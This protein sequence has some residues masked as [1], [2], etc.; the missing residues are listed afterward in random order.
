M[1]SSRATHKP[2][3]SP[4]ATTPLHQNPP[5]PTSHS[6][7]PS[8]QSPTY[9]ELP[10]ERMQATKRSTSTLPRKLPE[11]S[12]K[13]QNN[14]TRT[15]S[16]GRMTPQYSGI[17]KAGSATHGNVKSSNGSN[18]PI[19]AT[20]S[21]END[22]RF[23]SP[24]NISAR[25][26]NGTRSPSPHQVHTSGSKYA[27]PVQSSAL[28]VSDS[29]S[30][31]PFT[32]DTAEIASVESRLDKLLMDKNKR[33]IQAMESSKLS[34]V[35][36][37]NSRSQTPLSTISMNISGSVGDIS[38]RSNIPRKKPI[39]PP[40]P[41]RTTETALQSQKQSLH[42]PSTLTRSPSVISDR[43]DI[44]AHSSVSVQRPPSVFSNKS[45]RSSR[46][47]VSSQI[48]RKDNKTTGSRS[49]DSTLR[50]SM[51]SGYSTELQYSHR[52]V[53]ESDSVFRKRTMSRD[54]NISHNG[55]IFPIYMQVA[56]K[57][58]SLV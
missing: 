37:T 25:A 47:H 33:N 6:I 3:L 28:D 4:R 2:Q 24:A 46:S 32:I 16:D 19:K 36:V 8:P 58:C 42:P 14:R 49:R 51:E 22:T 27:R 35:P 41:P 7:Q 20:K 31:P 23:S 18:L 53:S 44:S 5:H 39:P 43:S 17:P 48:P 40:P 13:T 52:N 50:G 38:N 55:K 57:G 54:R 15:R 56:L 29:T 45:D 9:E 21:Y 1:S 12:T 26:I 34:N 11:P 30:P 10:D